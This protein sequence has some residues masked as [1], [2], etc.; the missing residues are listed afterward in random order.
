MLLEE[1]LGFS[2]NS[3]LP[4]N[5][6]ITFEFVSTDSLFCSLVVLELLVTDDFKLR[7][8]N[9]FGEMPIERSILTF[10]LLFLR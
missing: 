2:R 8:S 3:I 4:L 10:P 6:W 5:S 1:E 9:E 7:S